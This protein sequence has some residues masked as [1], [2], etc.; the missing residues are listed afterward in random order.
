M[1]LAIS[2]MAVKSA[3]RCAGEVR[4]VQP[5]LDTPRIVNSRIAGYGRAGRAAVAM[6]EVAKARDGNGRPRHAPK[7][8]RLLPLHIGDGGY[9]QYRP[10][11]SLPCKFRSAFYK[12]SSMVEVKSLLGWEPH[13]NPP[14]S[15]ADDAQSP[16]TRIECR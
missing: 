3:A 4:I 5:K 6:T 13:L 11:D 15:C 1:R 12:T 10:Q 9:R 16:N 14:R 7:Y 2:K 8:G